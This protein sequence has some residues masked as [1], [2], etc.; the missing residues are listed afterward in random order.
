MQKKDYLDISKAS[1]IKNKRERIA[2]RL[3]E[4]LP[5]ALSLGTL[6]GVLVFS[7]FVPAWV[8]IFVICFS[9]YYLL[10]ILYFSLHQVVGYI[11]VKKHLKIDW[12]EKLKKKNDWKKIYHVVILPTYKEGSE[13]IK[14]T[15][16]SLIQSDYP[17]EKL[18]VV[19]AVEK[20]AGSGFISMAEKIKNGYADKFFEFLTV[21]HPD[22]IPGEIAGKGSNVA[23]ACEEVKKLIDG[24]KIPYEDIL[25][26]S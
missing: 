4:I 26:S 2:Y 7:W 16:H 22:N 21:V 8:S 13:I 10:R 1:D 24:L 25:I 20:R 15:L 12:M 3:F 9:L 18:I 5:G 14:E 19:L 17:K 6:L 11:K 23:Y